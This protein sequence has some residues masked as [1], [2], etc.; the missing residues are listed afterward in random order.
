MLGGVG[1]H[2]PHIGQDGLGVEEGEKVY[3]PCKDVADKLGN[4]TI[5]GDCRPRPGRNMD[6]TINPGV[7]VELAYPGIVQVTSGGNERG[8][9]QDEISVLDRLEN[10]ERV[11]GQS[12][13]LEYLPRV[14]LGP[15]VDEVKELMHLAQFLLCCLAAPLE[16]DGASFALICPVFTCSIGKDALAAAASGTAAVTLGI[17]LGTQNKGERGSESGNGFSCEQGEGKGNARL[18]GVRGGALVL[19]RIEL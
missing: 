5:A 8:V 11:L 14:G 9:W 17:A 19:G 18:G 1:I 3:I 12:Y 7:V 13:A 16:G 6:G 15:A 4:Q 2:M 10:G